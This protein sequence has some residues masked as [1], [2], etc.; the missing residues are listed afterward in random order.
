MNLDQSSKDQVD[1]LVNSVRD[2]LGETVVGAYLFGSAVLGGLRPRSDLDV[3]VVS[4][5]PTIPVEKERLVSRLL[6][7]SGRPRHLELTILVESEIRPWRYPPRMDFQYGDWWRA[8][9]EAGEV[10]PWGSADNPDVASLIRMVVLADTPLQGPPPTEVFEPIPRQ[11]YRAALVHGID[12]LLAEI[13]TDTCNVVLTLA[14]IWIGC[15][16]DEIHSKDAAADWALPR[17]PER[18]QNTLEE[19]RALYLGDQEFESKRLRVGAR[20]YAE[21]AAREI[22]RCLSSTTSTSLGQRR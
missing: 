15:V 12:G 8:E 17:L 11:D 9:F 3:M 4:S 21:H 1:A 16:T 19:A 5:R 2:I 6:H 20:A 7:L 10:E 13:D 14:R 18:H 22:R